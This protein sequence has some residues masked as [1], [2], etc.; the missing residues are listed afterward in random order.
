MA[1]FPQRC[2]EK[3]SLI[4]ENALFAWFQSSKQRINEARGLLSEPASSLASVPLDINHN[5]RNQN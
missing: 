1:V 4:D 5:A 2:H 3:R